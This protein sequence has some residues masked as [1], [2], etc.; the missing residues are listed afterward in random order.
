VGRTRV[1]T[2]GDGHVV[3]DAPLWTEEKL[4]ILECYLEGF[5]TACKPAGGWYGLDLFAGAGLNYSE[6][7]GREIPSSPLIMLEAGP[8]AATKVLMCELAKRTLR[9]L[10]HRIG[11]YGD[12]AENFPGNVNE[13]IHGMLERVPVRAPAF[14]FLDP[15]GADL[16][17]STV[18]AIAAHKATEKY[19]VEQLILLPTDSGFMRLLDRR[20]QNQAGAA[21]VANIMPGDQWRDIWDARARGEISADEGRTEYVRYY[22]EGLERLGYE[23]VLDREVPAVGR[24][25]Y[26]LLYA[27]DH[28]KAGMKI[29]DYC[30][31]QVR[32]ESADELARPR[33]FDDKRP[34]RPTR[35]S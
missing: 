8:V 24:R 28:V 35:L 2:G 22:A 14:A 34:P 5:T 1:R 21:R 30:F 11:P 33:L 25:M 12:R 3:R 18:E 32:A 7:R 19:K 29:M 6:A 16:A 10:E 31:N 20:Q 23:K 27:T 13:E 26:F 4:L 9:A 15:E 17:W